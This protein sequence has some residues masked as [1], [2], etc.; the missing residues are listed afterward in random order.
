MV[1]DAFEPGVVGHEQP[2]RDLPQLVDKCVW[3][4]HS[5]GLTV[6]LAFYIARYGPSRIAPA[7]WRLRSFPGRSRMCAI[8]ITPGSRRRS[9]GVTPPRYA[10]ASMPAAWAARIPGRLSSMTAQ[11]DG[12]TPRLAAACRNRSGAGFPFWTSVALKIL[13]SNREYRPVRP[14]TRRR[15]SWSL[16]DATHAS[17]SIWSSASITPS[18]A[19]V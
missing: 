10:Y 3:R 1:D 16:L 18:T 19:T 14:R 6:G 15:W 11:A 7:Y 8:G 4:G 2:A 5:H 17:V 12:G 13:P 9:A